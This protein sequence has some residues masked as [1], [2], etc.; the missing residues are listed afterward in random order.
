MLRSFAP[1]L[2]QASEAGTEQA[3]SIY[4]SECLMHLRR[5]DAVTAGLRQSLD[6]L[7]G[8]SPRNARRK[9]AESG[10][11]TRQAELDSL[12]RSPVLLHSHALARQARLLATDVD[13]WKADPNDEG[14]QAVLK[15]L[16]RV[17]SLTFREL[18]ESVR[19]LAKG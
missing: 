16:N 14:R 2:P 12:L 10:L 5:L 1:I 11:I 17:E 3:A 18:D 6:Q 9:F 19:E 7:D 8:V 15:R 4:L 13:H